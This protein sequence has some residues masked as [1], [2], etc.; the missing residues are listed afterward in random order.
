MTVP[1][2]P[3][4]GTHSQYCG[5]SV[6][7][8]PLLAENDFLPDFAAIPDSVWEKTKLLVLNYRN[9][10]TGKTVTPD[11]YAKLLALDKERNFVVAQDAEQLIMI[12]RTNHLSVLSVL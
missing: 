11:F 9:S 12:Y 6:Y 5:G 7:R 3:V 1:G 10:P 8:L 4:A 2:Y